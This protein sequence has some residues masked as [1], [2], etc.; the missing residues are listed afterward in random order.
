MFSRKYLYYGNETPQ[1]LEVK[2]SVDTSLICQTNNLYQLFIFWPW[3]L[4]FVQIFH[5]V[6]RNSNIFFKSLTW[7]L[8]EVYNEWFNF[9]YLLWH[10]LNFMFVVEVF[11]ATI[12]S[13]INSFHNFFNLGIA[14]YMGL[15]TIFSVQ[16]F[17]QGIK[18]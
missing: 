13:F 3:N 4:Y 12:C 18:E 15:K 2:N 5:T 1:T 10:Y 9:H 14:G 7:K 6:P 16:M 17:Y 8:L 11:H